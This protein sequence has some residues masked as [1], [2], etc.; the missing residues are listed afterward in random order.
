MFAPRHALYVFVAT[1]ALGMAACQPAEGPAER[2]GKSL[3]KA[4]E[5]VAEELE[6]PP[7]DPEAEK[8]A[9]AEAELKRKAAE[10]E[11]LR[12]KK[13]AE[14]DAAQREKEIEREQQAAFFA[15][16]APLWRLSLPS[17]TPPLD[18]SGAQ[19]LEWGG[20]LR[21]L[22][23]DTPAAQVREAAA[24]AGGHA[25]LFRGGDRSVG[26]FQPLPAPLMQ[27]HKKLKRTFDPQGLFNP[28]RLYP[29]L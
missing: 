7:E 29:E 3:D 19:L 21:W 6:L 23:S 2:A 10:K 11:A 22:S 5:K 13:Q 12:A 25:T 14:K 1:C 20:A 4:A 26:V 15:D 17:K 28:G 24:R 9:A 16:D 18:L 27:I 8:K